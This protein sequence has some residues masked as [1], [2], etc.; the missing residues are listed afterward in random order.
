MSTLDFSKPVSFN[1]VNA[2]LECKEF[3][4]LSLS[5][6]LKVSLGQVNKI[7]K[8]F[9][10]K[11]S[12]EKGKNGYFIKDALSIISEIAAYRSMEKTIIARFNLS[13]APQAV[14]EMIKHNSVF[15]LDSALS[16]YCNNVKTKRICAYLTEKDTNLIEK[17]AAM[18][19]DKTNLCLYSI[20]L[21]LDFVS[22]S[23]YKY[24]NKVRTVIDLVCDNSAFAATNLFQELWKQK[25]I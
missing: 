13:I 3:T 14:K 4:Q 19:G 15:C 12:I 6:N 18:P 2:M 22:D 17:L 23:D 11:G 9:Q 20:D 25:I 7:V 21:P 10:Q 24:T 8:Y 5:Q 16:Y 1:I